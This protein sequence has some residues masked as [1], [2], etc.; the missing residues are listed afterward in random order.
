MRIL[1]AGTPDFAVPALQALCDSQHDVIAVYT[2][3]DRPAGRGQQLST[4]PVKQLALQYDIPVR[5]PETLKTTEQQ[6]ELQSFRPDLMVVAAYGL[7]LP[8]A[9]LDSPT[10]GCVNIHASLLPRWRGASPIQ[11]AI[12]HGDEESGVTLM[13][14]AEQLDAGDMIDKAVVTIQSSWSA[15]DLHDQLAQL[16]ARLLLDNLD[17]LAEKWQNARPQDES[18]VTYAPKL[19]KQ[20]ANIDWHKSAIQLSRE[21]RAY[22]PWPVSFTDFQQAPLRIW[23]ARPLL[24]APTGLPG[25]VM[26]HDKQGIDVCCG[27]GVLRIQ[28]LQFAGKRRCTAAEALNGRDLN[29]QQ[30]G[31]VTS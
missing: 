6:A 29:G 12:L 27:E 24:E 5:Q 4:S 22:N 17:T 1:F 2:Q 7:L 13:K 15:G 9:V 26:N 18:K 28:E 8:R 3:P 14:M 16:G 11:Q 30:L 23:R 19:E 10:L 20:Q 25:M 21:V 31:A